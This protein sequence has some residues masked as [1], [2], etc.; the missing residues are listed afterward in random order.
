LKRFTETCSDRSPLPGLLTG[1]VVVLLA[2]ILLS[3]LDRTDFWSMKEYPSAAPCMYEVFEGRA[4]LGTVFCDQPLNIQ[5]I[6]RRLGRLDHLTRAGCER[7]IPC[8]SAIRLSRNSSEMMVRTISGGKL[9]AA[10]KKIDVNRAQQ[11]DLAWVPGIGPTLAE[12]IVRERD[13]RNGFATIRELRTIQGIGEAK[14]QSLFLWL[15]VRD[16][17]RGTRFVTVT[18]AL[19]HPDRSAQATLPHTEFISSVSPLQAGF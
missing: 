8:G 17:T 3:T 16:A 18:E 1:G 2:Q 7:E 14:W 6:L 4:C 19:D 12:R 13:S 11:D 9:I 10:G 5:D 15:E